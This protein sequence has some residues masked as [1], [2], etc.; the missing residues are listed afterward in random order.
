MSTTVSDNSNSFWETIVDI[1]V[2][3]RNAQK[4]SQRQVAEYIG[5]TQSYISFFEKKQRP[6]AGL[7]VVSKYIECLNLHPN[8]LVVPNKKSKRTNWKI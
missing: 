1:L 2:Y 4:K 5:V 3:H 6:N 7:L 8:D